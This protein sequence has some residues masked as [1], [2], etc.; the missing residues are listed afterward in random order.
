MKNLKEN[1]SYLKRIIKR[2][3]SFSQAMLVAFMISG[4]LSSG[5]AYAGALVINGAGDV[6]DITRGADADANDENGVKAKDQG[7]SNDSI[8]IGKGWSGD[9]VSTGYG[10]VAV[11][12]Q[13]HANG[14]HSVAIA[15]GAQAYALNS[16]A[17]G[18]LAKT[19]PNTDVDSSDIDYRGAIAVGAK[20]LA[21]QGQATAVGN[22]A[23]ARGKQSVALGGDVVAAE[24]A[25]IAIGSDDL[26]DNIRLGKDRLPI[27]TIVE[28][29]S[30]NKD[31]D[32][33][34]WEFDYIDNGKNIVFRKKGSNATWTKLS[35]KWL[36][37]DL[38]S[39]VT[40]QAVIDKKGKFMNGALGYDGSGQFKNKYLIRSATIY[41]PTYAGGD[42][43]IAMG[44]RTVAAKEGSTAIG[45]LSFAL[46]EDSTAMG[47]HTYVDSDAVGATA[48]G[49]ESRAFA[50]NTLAVGN[51]AESTKVGSNAFGNEAKAV[52]EGSIA[53]GEGVSANAAIE[54]QNYKDYSTYYKYMIERRDIDPDKRLKNLVDEHKTNVVGH[55]QKD[56]EVKFNSGNEQI[57]ETKAAQH[58][59]YDE[60][61]NEI[62][63]FDL[64]AVVDS[65]GNPV[66]V[67]KKVKNDYV[68]TDAEKKLVLTKEIQA[69]GSIIYKDQDGNTVTD[70]KPLYERILNDNATADMPEG[71]VAEQEAKYK[72]TK[73]RA[74]K[75]AVGVGYHVVASGDNAVGIGSASFAAGSNSLAVGSMAYVDG[76]ARNSLAIGVG[77]ASLQKDS[78]ALGTGA[79]T[80]AEQSMAIGYKAK[81]TLKNSMSLGSHSL[82]DYDTD[83][84]DKPGWVARGAF[85]I[86]ANK[87]TGILSVGAKGQERRIVNLASGR[88]ATDAVNVAQLK[89]LED[90][91]DMADS[92]KEKRKISYVSV[93]YVDGG[94]AQKVLNYIDEKNAY[95]EYVGLKFQLLSIEARKKAGEQIDTNAIQSLVDKVNEL[96]TNAIKKAGT[97]KAKAL[98][99][100]GDEIVNGMQFKRYKTPATGMIDETG[101]TVTADASTEANELTPEEYRE[102]IRML[103]RA[104]EEDAIRVKV[105]NI[106]TDR[107]IIDK[108]QVI[109]AIVAEYEGS[110]NSEM[111]N[112]ARQAVA[113]TKYEGS[114]DINLTGSYNDA[115]ALKAKLDERI[116]AIKNTQITDD[117][118]NVLIRDL[119]IAKDKIDNVNKFKTE[120]VTRLAGDKKEVLTAPERKAIL[121]SN[122]ENNL[123][124]GMNSIAIGYKAEVDSEVVDGL[125]TEK[126]GLDSI[127][128]GKEAYVKG[129]HS[130]TVGTGSEIYGDK[131]GSLG[132]QNKVYADGSYGVGSDNIIGKEAG[133]DDPTQRTKNA[134][135]MG[136]EVKAEVD[137]SVYLGTHSTV[138]EGAAVGT[139][140]KVSTV[141]EAE[142]QKRDRNGKLLTKIVLSK[143]AQGNIV[144]TEVPIMIKK[145]T[146]TLTDGTTTT[147]G[148][149]GTVNSATVAGTT[150]TGF[151]GATADGAVSVGS[152][153]KERR[154]QNVAAGEI[155]ATSTDA[156]NGSQLYMV[157]EKAKNHY[158]SVNSTGGGNFNNDG[159][160]GNNAIA[161]GKDTTATQQDAVAMGN[162]A[163]AT[164]EASVA[165]G[166]LAKVEKNNADY[167]GAVALGQASLANRAKGSKGW[168]I[169]TNA[170]STSTDRTWQATKAA[171]SVGSDGQYNRTRQ[172]INVAAGSEDTDAVNVA[173]LK[174]VKDYVDDTKSEEKV[175]A[176]TA[177]TEAGLTVSAAADRPANETK[178]KAFEVDLNKDTLATKL[179]ENNSTTKT[180]L[181]GGLNLKYKANGA[182]E[183]STPLST[184]LDFKN[185]TDTVATVAANGEVKYD[186]SDAAKTKLNSAAKHSSVVKGAN[187][188]S[189]T[190]TGINTAGG[191]E[192]VVNV[193][194]MH[195]T[196]GA[197]TYAD[198][199][200]GTATLTHGD[201]TTATVTGLKD[202]KVTEATLANNTLTI[203]QNNGEA[204]KTVDLSSLAEKSREVVEGTANEIDVTPAVTDP[205]TTDNRK[206]KVALSE[207]IREKLKKA[208]TIVT[209]NGGTA[210]GVD[211]AYNS[212]GNLLAKKTTVDGKD[213]YDIKL[214]DKV[215]LGTDAAKQVTLDGT[216]GKGKV[217]KVELD[218]ETGVVKG[219]TNTT[220]D[221]V[222][223]TPVSG[224]AAT[225]DQLKV[226][227]DLAKD[228][229]SVEDVTATATATALG[230]TVTPAADRT[231]GTKGKKFEVD[232]NKDT[233]ATKLV[234]NNSTTKTTLENGLDLSY[235]ASEKD[236]TTQVGDTQ[237][238]T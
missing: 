35:E 11:G 205:N 6:K 48:I 34:K 178:G 233:L 89:T 238:T 193:K 140:N 151:A 31:I 213:T 183:Q 221:P 170:A 17:L 223:S 87:N 177:A 158:F 106:Y 166:H 209:V 127:A 155:S 201:G 64:K 129:N 79:K 180:T 57:K 149:K 159:A 62:I 156:I 202:T 71:T 160:T 27:K 220:W 3:I 13:S 54:D 14:Q 51:K 110:L 88:L 102:V 40:D 28:T 141:T 123:A 154:I 227:S 188:E 78:M 111:N 136:N 93:N 16:V 165:I 225:E 81:S 139:K 148:N 1:E 18:Y 207:A 194:D 231:D 176:T 26:K 208:G 174:K 24:Y 74:N 101:T 122:Y 95:K 103:D 203:K 44:S 56:D 99:A 97:D 60:D 19:G 15:K 219:L 61:G 150:Y 196:S 114:T 182:N 53:I 195:V 204:D 92:A 167:D 38:E 147:A 5:V 132:V 113:N 121:G 206:F 200:T 181:E 91:M 197:A 212:D 85:S 216:T 162:G 68:S 230:L 172:I 173:Q 12:M 179:V 189:V 45:T 198:D 47:I 73:E 43:A 138:A 126:Y 218:G 214:N 70:Y 131:A 90:R 163:A 9:D 164:S 66:F 130:A 8:A 222:T 100:L 157:A 186:L 144:Q 115:A 46:A 37:G 135:V 75:G 96:E 116:A 2:K 105:E 134:F 59:A 146:I 29:F 210:A 104:K 143:D 229:K 4:L 36:A 82:T 58:I 184:G 55:Y 86:P 72:H 142:E 67:S 49:K 112:L 128:I 137:N 94:D 20:S 25:T 168:D 42:A 187:V 235:K 215:T 76:K 7:L 125:T 10:A 117:Q 120:S 191:K 50:T 236:G 199:G 211:P 63:E 192:Y 21:M 226:V 185:G 84:L 30:D 22:M 77:A 52:G 65:Q 69:D 33:E 133:K 32:Y 228:A 23:Q 237:E 80:D 234:E 118:K 175:T 83:E 152:A 232:L 169:T 39:E 119:L 217:G 161:I 190:S 153:G 124:K 98:K 109:D 107:E 171:V 108:T 41:S 145:K 224:Q